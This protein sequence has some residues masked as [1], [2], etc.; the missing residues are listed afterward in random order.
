MDPSSSSFKNVVDSG[1]GRMNEEFNSVGEALKLVPTFRGNKQAFIG[2]VG[3]AFAVIN[4]PNL[5]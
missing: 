1:V 4:Q 2:N 5:I 3:T